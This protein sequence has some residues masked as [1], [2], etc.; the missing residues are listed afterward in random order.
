ADA[1]F[2]KLQALE[3]KYEDLTRQLADPEAHADKDRYY[4]LSKSFS[5]LEPVVA[6]F[7]EYKGVLQQTG[8][9]K[10]LVE[11][12]SDEDLRQLAR[13]ELGTLQAREAA[14]DRD[15]RALLT[16]KDPNDEKDIILEVRAGTGGEEASLFASE[17]VRM[18][19]RYAERMGFK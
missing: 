19:T 3:E 16:P 1:M 17:M 14:L 8:E 4:K 12:E 2:E 6:K 11:G 7:R 13:E 5:E 18:Y 10:A 9:A 15:L